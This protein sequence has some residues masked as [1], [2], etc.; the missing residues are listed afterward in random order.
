MYGGVEA[1]GTKV[2]CAVG[3]APDHLARRAVIPTTTPD[4]TLEKVAEFFAGERLAAVGI[5]SFG[6]LDLDPA[7]PRYGHITTTPK[8]GWT[9]AD[10]VGYLARRLKVPVALDTDVNGAAYAEHRWG[11]TRGTR[12]SAYVT[13]GTG[14]GGGIVADGHSWR[15]LAHP[16]MGH[17]PVSRHPRDEFA[18]SCRFH[19]DCLEGLASGPAIAAR[20]GR[21]T[22]D[23]GPA[24]D[25]AV[26]L[27]AWYL[28]QL[29]ASLVYT[30]SPQR[31]VLGGGVMGIPGLL[32]AV[33]AATTARLGGAL[34]DL[35]FV[36]AMDEFLVAP[37]LGD[38]A[39]VLGALGLAESARVLAS[40]P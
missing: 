28:A 31:I 5:A 9:G 11:A 27:E 38:N 13:V 4:E 20:A 12:V 35:P 16:E 7:S 19:G 15:G 34:D 33:R 32:D 2:V 1:G 29:V 6:P 14:I 30:V 23:L 22:K 8:A 39:G 37:A 18:G 3:S 26:E 17:V 25:E 10:L 40:T 21:P 24:R 36:S